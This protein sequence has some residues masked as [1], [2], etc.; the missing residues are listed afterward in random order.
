MI[1]TQNAQVTPL[2]RNLERCIGIRDMVR[3]VL[4]KMVVA[5]ENAQGGEPK[6]YWPNKAVR[7]AWL[8]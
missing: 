1:V 8:G 6:T 4:S 7:A 5:Y 2:P 3:H